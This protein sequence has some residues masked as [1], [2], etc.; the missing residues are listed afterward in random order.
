MQE[1]HHIVVL[2]FAVLKVSLKSSLYYKYNYVPNQGYIRE[3]VWSYD[4]A[5]AGRRD[6]FKVG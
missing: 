4:V 3:D 1:E 2:I 5:I 6:V